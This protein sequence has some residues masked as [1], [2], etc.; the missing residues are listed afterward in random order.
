[1]EDFTFNDTQR[2][3]NVKNLI[4]ISDLFNEKTGLP[5]LYKQTSTFFTNGDNNMENNINRL[6]T[7]YQTWSKGVKPGFSFEQVMANCY[8]LGKNELICV[9]KR[10][11]IYSKIN[12]KYTNY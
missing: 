9:C 12:S 4:E 2:A 11:K 7:I 5:A 1:M 8:R 10:D 3:K 6:V